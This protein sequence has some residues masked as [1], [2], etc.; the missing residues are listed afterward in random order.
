MTA[1]KEDK[2]VP[3]KALEP[4]WDPSLQ[5]GQESAGGGDMDGLQL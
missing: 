4:R 5:D 3:K 1:A 2:G